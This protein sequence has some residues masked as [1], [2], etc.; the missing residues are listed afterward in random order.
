MAKS[1]EEIEK[2]IL[3]FLDENSTHKGDGTLP[4]CG[5]RHGIA[6]ALGTCKNNL[7]RVTPIDFF[8]DG[9]TLWI[10]GN[11]GG[12][13]GN[14]RSN[15]NVSVGIYTRMDHSVENRSIQLW[16]KASLL[17]Y[18]K[19]KEQFMEIVTK[20]PMLDAIR[21]GMRV[22]MM[23]T[24]GNEDFEAKLDKSLNRLTLIKVEPERIALLI[25]RPDGTMEKLIWGKSK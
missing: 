13:L 23:G 20:F 9:L 1:K 21:Q 18:R 7:P 25:V 6:C 8:N 14:I 10:M 16:G 3:G 19:Q 15:P 11:A 4:G 22:G 2:E 12:K 17:T 24:A 5:L